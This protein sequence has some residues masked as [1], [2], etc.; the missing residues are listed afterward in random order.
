MLSQISE[1]ITM[2][3]E[4]KYMM[5]K[6]RGEIVSI[7]WGDEKRLWRIR[8]LLPLADGYEYLFSS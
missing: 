8:F 3:S 1:G 5:I 7:V 4:V 2:A 6:R